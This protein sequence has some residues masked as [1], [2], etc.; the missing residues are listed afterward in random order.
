L[1]LR[2]SPLNT[3]DS[4]IDRFRFRI[5]FAASIVVL[6]FAILIGRF[7]YLQIIRHDYYTTRAED[8]RISLVP[9]T[10]NRGV[11][12]DRNGTVLARNYSAFTLE[13]TPSKIENLDETIDSLGKTIEILPKDRR[14]FRN[15]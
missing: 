9:I 14:R 15:L 12:L 7:V 8:N 2:Y 10:P 13:I 4:E 6:A 3:Q 1:R 5:A 11:I